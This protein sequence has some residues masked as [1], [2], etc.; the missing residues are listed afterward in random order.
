MHMREWV[1]SGENQ[2]VSDIRAF[3]EF[4]CNTGLVDLPLHGRKFTCYKP[5]G[6]CKS[7]I[8][9]NMVNDVWVDK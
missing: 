7:R 5:Y 8:E 3:D 9:R 4:I 6:N 2:N 1:R